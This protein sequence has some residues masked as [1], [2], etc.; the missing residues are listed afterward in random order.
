[1]SSDPSTNKLRFT[2][3]SED[4]LRKK[5]RRTRLIIAAIVLSLVGLTA[6]ENY[7]LKQQSSAPIA[8][9]IAILAVF[10]IILILLFV[11]IILIA[12]NLV[13]IYHERKSKIIGSKFQ[14]KLIIAHLILALVPSILLSVTASKLFTFSI[15]SWFNLQVEQTLEQSMDVAR[16]YYSF[17]EQNAL[18]RARNVENFIVTGELYHH[19]KRQELKDLA[20]VKVREYNLGGLMVFDNQMERVVSEI[21]P[22]IAP[23]GIDIDY[24]EVIQK[25]IFV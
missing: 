14:T 6:L 11:L 19:D 10:N 8:N 18:E 12:K 1:M 2:H 16:D 15:G 9:N 20:Q 23:N 25:R 21:N 17:L 13:K 7:F 5:R 24:K 4:F 22:T 3:P